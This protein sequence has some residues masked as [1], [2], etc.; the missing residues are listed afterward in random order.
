MCTCQEV[1]LIGQSSQISSQS[2]TSKCIPLSG[3]PSTLA[4]H[5]NFSSHDL[6]WKSCDLYLF[7]WFVLFACRYCAQFYWPQKD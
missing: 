5:Q 2:F 6:V 1:E 3:L 7:F 4:K